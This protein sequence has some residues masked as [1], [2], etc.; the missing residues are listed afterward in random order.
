MSFTTIGEEIS[1]VI[2]SDPAVGAINRS[3]DG[4]YFE[5]QLQE[6]LKMPKDCLNVS[7]SVEEASIWWVIPNIITGK[8]DK[9]YITGFDKNDVLTNYIIVIPQGLYDLIGLN[10]AVLRELENQ[11]AKIKDGTKDLPLLSLNADDATQR[12][13]LRFNY[14]NVSVDFRYTD[15]FR[16]ILGF[17]SDLYGNYAIVPFNL[18]APNVAEFNSVNYFLLHS[19]LVN[20]GILFNNSYNQSISQV[21]IDVPAGSQI[22]Y[23]PFNPP[24]IQADELRGATRSLL[25][26]WI[27]DDKNRPVNTNQEYFT[28]RIVIR[29]LK[30]YLMGK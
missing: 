18:V 11:G 16:E 24:R 29:F 13:E 14:T 30:P 1:M 17:N 28:A 2:S 23:K 15:T 21:L 5:I 22:T 6:A 8:N 12:V 19:D 10:Q 3:A 4:S 9:I 25:R 26:F 20:K 27:T 7:V